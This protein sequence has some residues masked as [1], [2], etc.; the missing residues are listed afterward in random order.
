MRIS[1]FIVAL[2]LFA[3]PAL[4]QQLTPAQTTAADN[5]IDAALRDSA[6]WKRLAELTDRFGSRFS[7]TPNLERAIDWIVGEMKKDGFENVRT[8]PAMVMHWVRGTESAELV[9]P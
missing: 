8:E 4:A 6:A 1:R 7:G 5:L 9:V 3:S 2:T